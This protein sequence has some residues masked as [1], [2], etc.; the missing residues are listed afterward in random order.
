MT[1]RDIKNFLVDRPNG[2]GTTT[3]FFGEW[4]QV[5]LHCELG[6]LSF[7]PSSVGLGLSVFLC[8]E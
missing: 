5:H 8:Y 3:L 7:L 2:P 6:W 4:E 1:P